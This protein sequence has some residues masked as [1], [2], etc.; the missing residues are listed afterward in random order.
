VEAVLSSKTFE[1]FVHMVIDELWV[2]LGTAG[3]EMADAQDDEPEKILDFCLEK[4]CTSVKETV[5]KV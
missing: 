2:Q 4:I 1:I 3:E 5:R